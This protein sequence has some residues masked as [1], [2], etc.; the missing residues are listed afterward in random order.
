LAKAD[1][2]MSITVCHLEK[3]ERRLSECRK[4]HV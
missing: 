4:K 3:L 1:G 2:D